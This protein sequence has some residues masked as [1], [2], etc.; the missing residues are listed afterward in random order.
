M[1]RIVSAAALSLTASIATAATRPY[2]I[3]DQVRFDR[4]SAPQLAPDGESLVYQLRE[5][6]FDADKG[7]NSLWTLSLAGGKTAPQRITPA[8]LGGLRLERLVADALPERVGEL[9]R[10]DLGGSPR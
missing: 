6:D 8:E 7:V 1:L 2:S 5:T 3:D 10:R 9:G 4:V